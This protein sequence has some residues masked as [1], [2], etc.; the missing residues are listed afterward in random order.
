MNRSEY[1]VVLGR[2]QPLHVGHMEY[3]DCAKA[4]CKRLIIG[5]TNPNTAALQFHPA[6]PDRSKSESN[7]FSYFIRHEMID[8]AL[9]GL[10]WQVGSY[11]IV[12]ADLDALSVLRGFIPPPDRTTIFVTVYDAWGDEKAD[13]LRELGYP[14]E[15]LWRRDMSQRVT[16]GTELRKWM[17]GDHPWRHLVPE[18]VASAI[19]QLDALR[20]SGL[21]GDARGAV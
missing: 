16:S 4:G 21:R 12:P 17:R 11:G 2:F 9:R 20:S 18:G 3:L 10:G 14:V 1:G 6:D 5:V 19:E 13:R 8:S 15:V 7:P